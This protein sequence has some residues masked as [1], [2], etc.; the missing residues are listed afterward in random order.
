MF[1]FSQG[2]ISPLLCCRWTAGGTFDTGHGFDGSD[3]ITQT[4]ERASDEFAAEAQGG[5]GVPC[6]YYGIFDGLK[7]WHRVV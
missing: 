1:D 2:V 4:T 5:A 3:P 7:N 6:V